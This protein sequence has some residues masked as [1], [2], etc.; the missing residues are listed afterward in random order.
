MVASEIELE[1]Q[2]SWPIFEK[3]GSHLRE[4]GGALT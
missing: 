2:P 1:V 4:K 3:S